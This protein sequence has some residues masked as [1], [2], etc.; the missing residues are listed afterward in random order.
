MRE[1]FNDAKI[2]K[3]QS[4]PNCFRNH[5]IT[6]CIQTFTR[7]KIVCQNRILTKTGKHLAC[8]MTVV[9]DMDL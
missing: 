1:L 9:N 4:K 2:F 7:K 3:L 5:S 6:Y 8:H